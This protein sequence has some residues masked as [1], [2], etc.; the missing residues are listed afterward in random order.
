VFVNI[1]HFNPC[2]LF[3]CVG[4][5]V[6]TLSRIK[7]FIPSGYSLGCKYLKRVNMTKSEHSSNK[8]TGLKTAKMSLQ[9]FK[10][11]SLSVD[12]ITKHQFDLQ[13]NYC[14]KI[15]AHPG[16]PHYIFVLKL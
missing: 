1:C 8:S 11:L 6:H 12:Y 13:N 15:W 5:V 3:V 16:W 9:N 2:L 14:T 7:G 4:L 10:S